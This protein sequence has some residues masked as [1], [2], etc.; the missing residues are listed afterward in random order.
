MEGVNILDHAEKL[1]TARGD[2]EKVTEVSVDFKNAESQARE[3]LGEMP[4]GPLSDYRRKASFRWQDMKILVE[5]AENV[6]LKVFDC[7]Y[8]LL[9]IVLLSLS[10]LDPSFFSLI[11]STVF[12]FLIFIPHIFPVLI[13]SRSVSFPSP[14]VFL[15]PSSYVS[16]SSLTFLLFASFPSFPLPSSPTYTLTSFSPSLSPSHPSSFPAS[17]LLIPYFS[18]FVTFSSPFSP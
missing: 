1:T 7:S 14:S 6:L 11:C 13:F 4:E 2:G 15:F 9:T 17:A 8:C 5:G 18:F 12:L 10:S 16:P 3:L